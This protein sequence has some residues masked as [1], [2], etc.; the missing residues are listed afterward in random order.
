M[1][2]F[3]KAIALAALLFVAPLA[4]AETVTQFTSFWSLG[5]SLSDPGNLYA[6]T[7][8]TRPASPPY[9]QGRFSNGPVWAEHVAGTFAANG[10]ATG[11][12]AFGGAR[13]IG[14]GAED[15]I[16]DLADQIGLFA[17]ASAG[18]LGAR[19]VVS[20]WI[21]NNDLIFNGIPS[22]HA[23]SV[24]RQA[25][26]AVG[27][28]AL[29]LRGLGVRDVALF[30]MPDLGQTPLYAL[31][32]DPGA[33]KRASRGSAAYNRTLAHQTDRLEK[34]GMNVITI[35]TAALFRALL[36]D[37]EKFGVA[38]AT[39]PC[40]AP[41]RPAC[42]AEQAMQLAFF[43]P[44]H[45]NAVIHGEIAA[46]AGGKI[47]PVPLPAPAFLLLGALAGLGLAARRRPA[48]GCDD[49]ALPLAAAAPALR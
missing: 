21:G 33:Q 14:N 26:R 7:G 34:A 1:R 17:G 40:L 46:A 3:P 16:P 32:G 45:P 29:A 11:N 31:A 24:G 9:W 12:F 19:P 43:D 5:D 48:P 27:D 30:T 10:L 35:D 39:V 6:A 47:A 20:M 13:A 22:H 15:Q 36:A 18:H 4:R 49:T 2:P 41:G 37:P 25:A 28:G 8:G 42:S 38:N 44:V 23:V